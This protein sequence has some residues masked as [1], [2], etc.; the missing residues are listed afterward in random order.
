[1]A[2]LSDPGLVPHTVV[3]ALGVA[4]QPGRSLPDLLI[5]ALRSKSLLL[6]LDNCEHVLD[7]CG[8]L[9][10]AL[11]RRG[12]N[13]RIRA[14][15][16][17]RLEIAGELAYRVPSLSLPRVDAGLA[18]AGARQSEA[19]SLFVA[20]VDDRFG[21]LTMGNRAALPRQQTSR[22]AMPRKARATS[23]RPRSGWSGAVALHRAGEHVEACPDVELSCQYGSRRRG[24]SK[25]GGSL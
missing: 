4:E 10:D 20:R 21:L 22:A 16:R 7:A 1:M 14:T 24:V 9:A 12:P 11:L 17:E 2:G 6:L 23:L 25:S 8:R 5:D 18:P 3:A 13:L 19:V 15:S